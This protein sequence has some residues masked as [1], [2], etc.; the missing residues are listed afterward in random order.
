V[1][2]R[3]DHPECEHSLSAYR[4]GHTDRPRPRAPMSVSA[5]AV[6][7]KSAAQPAARIC[8][9]ILKAA[10]GGHHWPAAESRLP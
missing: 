3:L 5:A 1:Q 10:R 4:P 2:Q 7:E 8:S 6:S 9:T